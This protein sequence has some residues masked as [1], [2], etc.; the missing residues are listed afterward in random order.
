M[1]GFNAPLNQELNLVSVCL[2]IWRRVLDGV[3]YVNH[4][5]AESLLEEVQVRQLRRESS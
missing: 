1:A 4:L 5:Q 3:G 2:G